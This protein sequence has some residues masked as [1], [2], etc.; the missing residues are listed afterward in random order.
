MA[1]TLFVGSRDAPE[2]S[3]ASY[4]AQRVAQDPSITLGI[5]TVLN[6]QELMLLAFVEP[7]AKAVRKMLREEPS[8]LAPASFIQTH[9]NVRL[10]IDRPALAGVDLPSLEQHGWRL[11][12]I[13]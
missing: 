11:T 1:K 3:A 8:P 4:L 6:A 9:P 13:R 10:Y 5:A 2:K 12:E 7:K